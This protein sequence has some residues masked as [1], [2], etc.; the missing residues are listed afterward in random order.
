MKYAYDENGG[1]F[2]WLSSSVNIFAKSLAN[3]IDIHDWWVFCLVLR[4]SSA[5]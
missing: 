1:Y 5:D 2:G 4:D 3:T